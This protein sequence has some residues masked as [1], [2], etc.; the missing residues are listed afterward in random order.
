MLVLARRINE[1]IIIGDAIYISVVDIKGD[2]VKLG[3]DAPANVKVYRQE[4][5]DAI[6]EENRKAVQS[7]GELPSLNGLIEGE[8]RKT[9]GQ[10]PDP[11]PDPD[12][13]K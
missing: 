8:T 5:F 12:Q 4:I 7:H 13:D 9:S 3:I 1:R 6:Q 11:G 2:Q 10:D